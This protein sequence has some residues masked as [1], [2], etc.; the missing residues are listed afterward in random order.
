MQYFCELKAVMSAGEGE[1]LFL[2]KQNWW[3]TKHMSLFLAFLLDA[4]LEL[5]DK[6]IQETRDRHLAS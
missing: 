1:F 2:I 6:A 5:C 3:F 4:V